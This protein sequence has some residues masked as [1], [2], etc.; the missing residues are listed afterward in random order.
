[1]SEQMVLITGGSGF[2]GAAVAHRLLERHPGQCLILTDIAASPRLE[3]LTQRASF[4][5]ADLTDTSTCARLI[6]P[7]VGTVY[8]FASLVSPRRLSRLQDH[9]QV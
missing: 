2:L 8:H 7:E 6:T 1:M 4:V 9:R 3:S 5:Q